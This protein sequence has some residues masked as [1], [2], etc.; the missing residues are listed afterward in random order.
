[1]DVMTEDS[2]IA[3]SYTH[4]DVYKRQD[5]ACAMAAWTGNVVSFTQTWAQALT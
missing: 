4:L 5:M 2:N 1:M 3:V